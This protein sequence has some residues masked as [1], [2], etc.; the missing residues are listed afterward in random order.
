[1]AT[2]YVGVGHAN[3]STI[4]STTGEQGWRLIQQP[5][6]V[7]KDN[8]LFDTTD[9]NEEAIV[10]TMAANWYIAFPADKSYRIFDSDHE[11]QITAGNFYVY[12]YVTFNDVEYV[13]YKGFGTAR[14]WWGY[15]IY[16]GEVAQYYYWYAG[17]EH[18]SQVS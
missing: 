3:N 1:M 14:K 7:T 2:V 17:Q 8:P 4:T 15:T 12:S 6:S 5:N 13:V 9:G 11:D 18:P 10:G 16:G